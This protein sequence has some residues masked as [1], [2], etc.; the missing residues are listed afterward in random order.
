[1]R[2]RALGKE[3][4]KEG[5]VGVDDLMLLDLK[6]LTIVQDGVSVF[7]SSVHHV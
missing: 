2:I 5:I 3:G 4:A 6:Y 1:M 7:V